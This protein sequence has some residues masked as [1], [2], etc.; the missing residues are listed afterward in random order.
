VRTR[1]EKYLGDGPEPGD[2]P[3]DVLVLRHQI[4]LLSACSTALIETMYRDFSDH[5]WAA[6]WASGPDID[7]FR[8]W[9]LEEIDA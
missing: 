2:H 5:C 4:P 7:G 3:G 9:L 6:G 1:L 8:E